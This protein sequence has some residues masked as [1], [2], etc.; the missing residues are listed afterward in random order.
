[1]HFLS[2][3]Y[4]QCRASTHDPKIK[5][6]A[7]HQLSQL[8]APSCVSLNDLSEPHFFPHLE[9]WITANSLGRCED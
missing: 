6:Q 5:S 2:N 4:T 3:L 7:L 9:T 1:M 8:G